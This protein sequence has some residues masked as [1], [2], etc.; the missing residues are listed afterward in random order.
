[1]PDI[2]S[3]GG[4]D[5]G[6]AVRQDQLGGSH[7]KGCSLYLGCISLSDEDIHS[8]QAVCSPGTMEGWWR[9]SK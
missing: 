6:E 5:E 4:W 7:R 2:V 8:Q 1:M 3:E 9:I